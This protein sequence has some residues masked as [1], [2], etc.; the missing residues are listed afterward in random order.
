M[1]FV[2]VRWSFWVVPEE[3]V[4]LMSWNSED[5]LSCLVMVGW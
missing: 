1:V 3:L 4:T 2:L 5:F